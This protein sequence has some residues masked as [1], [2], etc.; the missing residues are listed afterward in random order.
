MQRK[1]YPL[2]LIVI[3]SIQLP[4]RAKRGIC[5][6]LIRAR[7]LATEGD[8]VDLLVTLHCGGFVVIH[9]EHR[10]EFCDLQ[11]IVNFFRQVQ[12]L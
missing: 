1:R 7:L 12:Q 10:E 9:V 6:S 3:P 2:F 5:F 8:V 11:Q 4:F